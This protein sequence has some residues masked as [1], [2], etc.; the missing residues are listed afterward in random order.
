MKMLVVSIVISS[1]VLTV[2]CARIGKR[3]HVNSHHNA[4][5]SLV[6]VPIKR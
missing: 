2:G 3:G 4:V 6:I 1:L 5:S